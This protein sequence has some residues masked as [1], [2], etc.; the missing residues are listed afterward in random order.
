MVELPYSIIH[1]N[2]TVSSKI[3]SL[4]T[5]LEGGRGGGFMHLKEIVSYLSAQNIRSSIL[6]CCKLNVATFAFLKYI[7]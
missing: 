7:S 2:A 1:I 4:L 6:F 5:K 3:L